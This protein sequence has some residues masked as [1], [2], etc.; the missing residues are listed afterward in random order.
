MRYTLFK[1]SMLTR[2]VTCQQTYF[3]I[4]QFVYFTFCVCDFTKIDL[5]GNCT[6]YQLSDYYGN[7]SQSQV[8]RFVPTRKISCTC[9]QSD[10][11][12]R[13]LMTTLLRSKFHRMCRTSGYPVVTL[14][15]QKGRRFGWEIYRQLN[16]TILSNLLSKQKRI[17]KEMEV[18]IYVLS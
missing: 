7:S 10:C 1:E 6:P 4:L 8:F 13:Y 11:G 17:F 9:R 18:V 15:K 14:L 3:S 16:P 5:Q 12:F 2:V